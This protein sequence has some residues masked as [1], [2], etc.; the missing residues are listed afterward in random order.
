MFGSR[1]L[2]HRIIKDGVLSELNAAAL[3]KVPE[4]RGTLPPKDEALRS[5]FTPIFSESEPLRGRGGSP[6]VAAAPVTADGA[7]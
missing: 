1:H 6:A 3:R 4:I 7:P 2:C 5:P